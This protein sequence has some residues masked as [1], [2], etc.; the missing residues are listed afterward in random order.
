MLA[1]A[2]GESGLQC[3]CI[4]R[5]EEALTLLKDAPEDLRAVAKRAGEI[6][7]DVNSCCGHAR[8][9]TLIPGDRGRLVR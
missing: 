3:G 1:E 2:A 6:R 4:G 8:R 5:A 9:S 7:D